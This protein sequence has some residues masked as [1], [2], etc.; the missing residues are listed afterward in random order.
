MKAP[1][2]PPF[3]TVPGTAFGAAGKDPGQTGAVASPFSPLKI[4]IITDFG[5]L[6]SDKYSLL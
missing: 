1:G 6:D 4:L 5:E 2:S 3:Q